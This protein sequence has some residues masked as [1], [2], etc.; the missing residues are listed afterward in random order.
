MKP[1]VNGV[2]LEN[3]GEFSEVPAG[4]TCQ[5]CSHCLLGAEVSGP[6]GPLPQSWE[7]EAG[8]QLHSH[9]Q[10]AA[11]TADLDAS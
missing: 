3:P 11:V 7:L 4:A 2:G 10:Q 9:S 5:V 1:S 6:M 8:I